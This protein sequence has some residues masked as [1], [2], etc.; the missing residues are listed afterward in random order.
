MNWLNYIHLTDL[1]LFHR[2]GARRPTSFPIKLSRIVSKTADG[3]LY[4]LFMAVFGLLHK[5]D[6]FLFIKTIL[7]AFCIERSL[8]FLL[9]NSFK[10]NRPADSISGFESNITPND[11][12]SFPSGHTSAAFLFAV[13]VGQ[14]FPTLQPWLFVWA[15][16]VALSRVLLGVHFPF[17]TVVGAVLGSSIA[18][19]VV[20]QGVIL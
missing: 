16:L 14:T 6:G 10:R 1:W 3:Q 9:K 11:Q 7:I 15:S 13:M 2:F 18:L 20:T 17:D 5:Q 12:F 19:L 4:L 8:Y